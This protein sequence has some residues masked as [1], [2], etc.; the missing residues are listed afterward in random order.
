MKLFLTITM[1]GVVSLVS[2]QGTGLTREILMAEKKVHQKVYTDLRNKQFNSMLKKFCSD[3]PAYLEAKKCEATA[4]AARADYINDEVSKTQEGKVLVDAYRALLEKK[5]TDK[6]VG[7]QVVEAR[8]K[9]DAYVRKSDITSKSNEAYSAVYESV[10]AA[11]KNSYEAAFNA[12]DAS[13][14]P[15]VQEYVANLKVAIA[16]MEALETLIKVIKPTKKVKKPK[17]KA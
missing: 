4:M 17:T 13:S 1:L 11:K 9:V 12:L 5:K 3:D 8:K 14:D 6:T 15:V 10:D 7:K 16:K 2:A